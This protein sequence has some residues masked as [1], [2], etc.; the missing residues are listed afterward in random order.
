MNACKRKWHKPCGTWRIA[1]PGFHELTLIHT[2]RRRLLALLSSCEVD[3]LACTAAFSAADAAFCTIGLK[4][5]AA[6]C[7]EGEV[8]AIISGGTAAGAAGVA[9]SLYV[10]SQAFCSGPGIQAAVNLGSAFLCDVILDKFDPNCMS[11]S[12][13]PPS[14]EIC[15]YAVPDQNCHLVN[16]LG[17][18][19]FCCND[20]STTAGVPCA[21]DLDQPFCGNPNEVVNNAGFYGSVPIPVGLE[22]YAGCV[23]QKWQYAFTCCGCPDG[24]VLDL[25]SGGPD[26]I[27]GVLC[28]KCG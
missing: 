19:A 9:C 18:S 15:D 4:Q 27:S 12:P 22:C 25:S 23:L 14:P 26:C 8:A 21:G 28:K 5:L 3:N 13:P 24:Y 2:R 20:A 17:N 10:A 16:K 7:A 1:T 11:S 6:G